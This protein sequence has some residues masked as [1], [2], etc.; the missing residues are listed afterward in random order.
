MEITQIH[1]FFEP[2]QWWAHKSPLVLNRVKYVGD[3]VVFTQW[4]PVEGISEAAWLVPLN[5]SEWSY[6]G[7]E[8]VVSADYFRDK[9][10]RMGDSHWNRATRQVFLLGPIDREGFVTILSDVPVTIDMGQKFERLTQ[11]PP[12]PSEDPPT[13]YDRILTEE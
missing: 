10:L 5:L 7:F 2:G 8:G 4:H 12:D 1:P 6:L 13:A 3:T 9:P 11:G